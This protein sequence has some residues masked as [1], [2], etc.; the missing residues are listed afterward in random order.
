MGC[1]PATF[2]FKGIIILLHSP[3]RNK[4][5]SSN[6]GTGYENLSPELLHYLQ[7]QYIY[8]I[9][10][11]QIPPR[12]NDYNP[13][14]ADEIIRARLFL[15]GITDIIGDMYI[16]RY[17]IALDGSGAK[18]RIGIAAKK[19]G[20]FPSVSR[21]NKVAFARKY[22]VFSRQNDIR[23]TI[24]LVV[25]PPET[26]PL[27]K[28]RAGHH[29]YSNQLRGLI[30]TG[31]KK[32]GVHVDFVGA[33]P[34][35]D[36]ESRDVDLHFHL[37]V[38]ADDFQQIEKFQE[39]LATVHGKRGAWDCYVPSEFRENHFA[40]LEYCADGLAKSAESS[41][42]TNAELA[43]LYRQT[44]GLHLS[45]STGDFHK[46]LEDLSERGEIV[47]CDGQVRKKYELPKNLTPQRKSE[48]NFKRVGFYARRVVNWKFPD[49]TVRQAVIAD[50]DIDLCEG[51]IREVYDFCS[52][53]NNPAN[54]KIIPRW[55]HHLDRPLHD[56]PA[57]F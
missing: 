21:S 32:L 41:G 2:L 14:A 20:F 19:S 34:Q 55:G 12:G 15:G 40:N 22:D 53:H 8:E 56:D 51:G 24:Q 28:F 48:F 42:W 13:L 38:R 5:L 27:R 6:T 17:A 11:R 44:K 37:T 26:V 57:P 16:H 52:D 31:R 47:D 3:R 45:R 1:N 29:F 7:Y 4:R 35:R 33:H 10:A 54:V 30:N 43:E 39:Y 9:A 50:G 46:F 25:R 36:S 18:Q 23:D 49:G